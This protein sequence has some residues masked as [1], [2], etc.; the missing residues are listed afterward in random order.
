MIYSDEKL[1]KITM[2]MHSGFEDLCQEEALQCGAKQ[3]NI[4]PGKVELIAPIETAYK[5]CLYSRYASRILLELA[6][7]QAGDKDQF[8]NEAVQIA[9]ED[10]IPDG[11]TIAIDCR[12]HSTRNTTL[13]HSMFAAQLLKDAICDR[14]REKTKKRPSVDPKFPHLRF[15][16]TI[17]QTQCRI[18]LDFS[19]EPLHK[20]G[21][22]KAMTTAPLKENMAAAI[23][24]RGGWEKAARE[25]RLF[26]DPMCGSGTFAIEAAFMAGG[27]APAIH[28]S[29]FGFLRWKNHAPGLWK[30][31]QEKAKMEFDAGLQK[32]NPIVAVEIDSEAYRAA[33]ENIDAAGLKNKIKLIHA[34]IFKINL[35]ECFSEAETANAN[36][37]GM[38]AI[39]PPY[40]NR[41]S[42]IRHAEQLCRRI[43]LEFPQKFPNWKMAML[44]GSKE[45]SI[46]TGLRPYKTNGIKNGQ[47][48]SV[49]ACFDFK[50]EQQFD[51]HSEKQEQGREMFLNRLKKKEKQFDRWIKKEKINGYRLYDADMPEYAAAID[52]YQ[53]LE[54]GKHIVVAE[55]APP[56]TIPQQ[57]RS[58][59]LNLI[60][61][62][63]ADFFELEP[64]KIHLKVR[65]KQKGKKQYEKSR[66]RFQFYTMEENGL[67]FQIDFD[68]YLDTGLFLD[69]RPVRKQIGKMIAEI[70]QNEKR[71]PL[72]MNLFS[73]TCTASVYA[74]A[75][76]AET[77]SVDLSNTYLEWGKQ[78]FALNKLSLK[79]HRFFREDALSFIKKEKREFDLIFI[80]PPT[81][82]NSKKT[83]KTFSVEND[84]IEIIQ[85]AGE[86]LAPKGKILFSNNFR[87]F[88][89]DF[90]ALKQFQI[91]E[92][93]QSTIDPDFQQNKKIHQAWI[94]KKK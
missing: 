35:E 52:C 14:M 33:K 46:A 90:E 49:L 86:V 25:G 81:F 48:E 60:L 11:A 62:S 68:R 40:G 53:T 89:L 31:L 74:A 32:I 79:P 5:L 66:N 18:A 3:A 34:D 63:V 39:N 2:I 29:F 92:I 54:E 76:G 64:E 27:I 7:I 1:E 24:K 59:R 28:R 93:S 36:R 16:L 8:Y 87:K 13:T 73:Y 19:G 69:H 65:K 21:Y 88:K 94:L 83:A 12:I 84:Y 50:D 85:K 82:S 51:Y 61:D 22:R 6:S 41:I 71:T 9:W 23:L 91:T 78:N 77:V 37:L 4:K 80:D 75:A 42:D 15:S 44:S 56:P 45:L 47:I 57:V 10:E 58:R 17:R 70:K 72:F 67:K 20:R 43:G 26:L 30:S 38:I 55:Y